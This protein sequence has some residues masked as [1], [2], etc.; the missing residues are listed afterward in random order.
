M[1]LLTKFIEKSKSDF[2][3]LKKS[4]ELL[5]V[6]LV[7][8]IVLV[9]SLIALF[10]KPPSLRTENYTVADMNKLMKQHSL[11]F[12]FKYLCFSIT[13]AFAQLPLE[14][15]DSAS[16]KTKRNYKVILT[17]GAAIFA[18]MAFFNAIG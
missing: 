14:Y 1:E 7:L 6:A 2:E 17:V 11:E 15:L 9:G 13:F 18:C 10:Y 16:Q 5:T 4:G 8:A 12:A 3:T